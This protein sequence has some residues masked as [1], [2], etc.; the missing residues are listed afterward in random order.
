MIHTS[1]ERQNKFIKKACY[2]LASFYGEAAQNQRAISEF[3]VLISMIAIYFYLKATKSPNNL[4][5]RKQLIYQIS[6]CI[7]MLLQLLE[8]YG[9][10]W[11]EI[12]T[13]VLKKLISQKKHL[14]IMKFLKFREMRRM[15]EQ[16][17]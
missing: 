5:H 14:A 6:D 16:N 3:S 12:R 17:E 2:D 11:E 10:S 15:K 7:I 8:I 1:E 13:T 4:Q 9:I